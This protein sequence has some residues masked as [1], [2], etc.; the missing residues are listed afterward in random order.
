MRE[1]RFDRKLGIKTTGL[2]EWDG[3]HHYNRYEATP[4][5]ALEM[6]S[7][8]YSLKEHNRLVDFGCGKGRVAF[9]MNK[10]FQ[11][12]VIGIEA[13]EKTYNEALEN[14][15]SYRRKVKHIS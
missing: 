5:K 13:N 3:H 6:L 15:L 9:Y 2:R 10:H 12:P 8:S 14:K 4:Y 7:K 11:I 1:K